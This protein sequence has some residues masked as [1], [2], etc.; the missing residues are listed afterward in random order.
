MTRVFSA[1]YAA[2]SAADHSIQTSLLG[3]GIG[4]VARGI[5]TFRPKK[6]QGLTGNCTVVSLF[7]SEG[8]R[9]E[10]CP[11]HHF[12]LWADDQWPIGD[13]RTT[14]TGCVRL[15]IDSRHDDRAEA[16]RGIQEGLDVAN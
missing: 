15:S 6:Y 13:R 14:A 9:F 10:S 12:A 4:N 11:V 16:I 1:C 7:G 2:G 3:N 8:C 5:L